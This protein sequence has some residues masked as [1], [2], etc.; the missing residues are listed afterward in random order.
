VDK[1]NTLRMPNRAGKM[2]PV[3]G[4]LSPEL[5]NA[6]NA[7]AGADSWGKCAQQELDQP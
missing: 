2:K 1:S 3:T 6:A 5:N 4:E 7:A